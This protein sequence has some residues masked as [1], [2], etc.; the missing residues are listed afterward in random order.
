MSAELTSVCHM[1]F[2]DKYLQ[3]LP[4]FELGGRHIKPYHITIAAGAVLAPE[5]V[6]AAYAMTARL[7][8]PPDGEMPAASWIVLREGRGPMYLC[9]YDW[10]WGNTVQVRT[11]AAAEPFV[12]CPD[13]DPAHFV[14]TNRPFA[15]CVWELATLEHERAAWVRHMLAPH[16]PDLAAYLADRMPAAGVGLPRLPAGPHS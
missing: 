6:E 3:P 1:T 11:A 4:A 7:L 8:S 5:V 15:G 16:E 9:V 13:D 14:E 10:V 12:G 2:H